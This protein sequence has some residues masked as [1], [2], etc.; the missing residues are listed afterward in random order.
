M[1]KDYGVL[2]V[3]CQQVHPCQSGGYILG[4][5]L[6]LDLDLNEAQFALTQYGT[7]G[8]DASSRERTERKPPNSLP[9]NPGSS[10]RGTLSH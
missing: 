7:P 3:H 2:P 4:K 1:D 5:A 8:G 6:A 10:T 9:T